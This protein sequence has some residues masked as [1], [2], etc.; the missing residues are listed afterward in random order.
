MANSGP[1]TNGSQFFVCF[2]ELPHLNGKHVVFGKCVKGF[3]V[4]DK[5]ERGGSSNGEPKQE[6]TIVGCG[7]VEKKGL[8]ND[9]GRS[10]GDGEKDRNRNRERHRKNDRNNRDRSRE[11]ERNRSREREKHRSRKRDRDIDI[12]RD[13]NRDN[14][15]THSKSAKRS[16]SR[17]S[18][19]NKSRRS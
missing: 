9:E 18:D 10:S 19:S 1:N 17:S 6:I 4:L 15:R 13:I 14:K 8:H 2:K 16:R 11:R 5:I 12:D 7:E 3:D